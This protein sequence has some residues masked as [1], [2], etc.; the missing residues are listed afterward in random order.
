MAFS[1][2][3][4]YSAPDR[5]RAALRDAG[6]A[7]DVQEFGKSTR[8]AEEAAAAVGTTVGQIV[9]SLVF[10]AGDQPV[11]ALVSG[12]NQLDVAKLA[13]LA[14]TSVAKAGAN[15]VRV[16]TSYSI[17]GVPPIGFPSPIP[18]YV[19]R[20]L[21]KYDEVWAAAGTPRHV[22]KI[23]PAELVRLTGGIVADVSARM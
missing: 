7:I 20:D 15:F 6:V 19:D 10:V 18:T 4:Q 16:A 12:S 5:V 13:V 14:G 22:F 1:M 17:G 8:T 11:L 21:L 2:E 9:K 23:A 3:P